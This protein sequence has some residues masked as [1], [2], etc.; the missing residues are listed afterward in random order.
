M[1]DSPLEPV[2]TPLADL[3]HTVLKGLR[4]D[5]PGDL[6]AAVSVTHPA[7]NRGGGQ[8]YVLAAT[9]VGATLTPET[10]G[11]LWG[12]SLLAAGWE[13]PLATDDIWHDSR[14]P[15]LQLARLL[16][17]VDASQHEQIR[18]VSGAAAMPSIWDDDGLVILSV[19]LDR[20]ADDDTIAI[21]ARHE[22]LV[23]SAVTIAGI[24]ERSHQKSEQVLDALASRAT[25]EQ[26]KG[27]IMALRRC[28]PADAWSM[29]RAVSQ[30]ANIKVREL[31]TAFVEHVEQL[32]AQQANDQRRIET[33]A[34]ARELA[35]GLWDG[36]HRIDP[37]DD[38][39]GL[40]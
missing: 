25:I 13:G 36:L 40:N 32:P 10:T 12:P 2:A 17:R 4:N 24:A 30:D 23:T 27:A 21:L 18:R 14:W 11:E 20:P 15:H 19:Y 28:A 1:S 39:Q 33:R 37:Y 16:E 5:L 6:G 34:R 3:L 22:P 26:A 38:G 29:L 35:I 9:G 7:P 31:A 8:L